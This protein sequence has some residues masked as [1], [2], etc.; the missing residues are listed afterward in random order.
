MA[1]TMLVI[2]LFVGAGACQSAPTK[3]SSGPAVAPTSAG[4]ESTTTEPPTTLPE[5]TTTTSTAPEAV[6]EAPVAT[7]TTRA[8]SAPTTVVYEA[9][10]PQ[11][12]TVG[13]ESDAFWSRLAACESGN[14]RGSA[15][16]F[17]FMGGTAEKVGYYPGASYEAQRAM[18]QDW[19]ARLRAE[20][21]SPGST[22]GWPT[23]W[24]VA[25]AGGV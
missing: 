24:W 17:Q 16:Q 22:S 20:G 3:Q 18:A 8:R 6:E 25:L 4:P 2:S 10:S 15:N 19:A 23:C 1:K 5:P 12:R 21:T 14:G 13:G 7:R 9:P 11:S